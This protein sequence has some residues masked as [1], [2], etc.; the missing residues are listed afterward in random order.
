VSVGFGESDVSW[1]CKQECEGEGGGKG[2]SVGEELRRMWV[3][4]SG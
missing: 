2:I 4:E 1:E 3:V